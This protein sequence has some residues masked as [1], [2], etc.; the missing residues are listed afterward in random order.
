MNMN[1]SKE[2]VYTTVPTGLQMTEAYN[3]YM[4]DYSWKDSRSFQVAFL[5]KHNMVDLANKISKIDEINLSLVAGWIC[6]ML[7]NGSKVMSYDIDYLNQYF[8]RIEKC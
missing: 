3:F 1:M 8:E 5:K 6:R 7:N 4:T 2:P